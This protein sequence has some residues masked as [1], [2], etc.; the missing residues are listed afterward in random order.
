MELSSNQV[1][2]MSL[3]LTLPNFTV[4]TLD[5]STGTTQQNNVPEIKF[6]STLSY[7]ERLM[8]KKHRRTELAETFAPQLPKWSGGSGQQFPSSSQSSF[9]RAFSAGKNPN[10]ASLSREGTLT[11]KM[12]VI[13]NI[14]MHYWEWRV[15]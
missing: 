12:F 2:K 6:K 4:R 10:S 1:I 13:K 5:E 3:T 14:T 7:A 9:S 11:G 8:L 15:P